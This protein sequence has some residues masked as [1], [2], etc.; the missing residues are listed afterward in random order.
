MVGPESPPDEPEELLADV[1]EEPPSHD[2]EELLADE[3]PEEVLEPSPDD[4]LEPEPLAELLEPL[5]LAG[6]ELLEVADAS[7][8]V[9]PGLSPPTELSSRASTGVGTSGCPR[10]VV[11]AIGVTTAMPVRRT[12]RAHGVKTSP[13]RSCRHRP[14]PRSAPARGLGALRSELP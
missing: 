8:P 9:K 12:K 1:P 7:P 4:E 5:P 14:G 2:P 10:I 6:P 11:H 13:S 3:P